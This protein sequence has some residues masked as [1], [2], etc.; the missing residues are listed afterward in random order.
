[1]VYVYTGMHKDVTLSR[2]ANIR[3]GELGGQFWVHLITFG[4]G[5]LLGL[6]TTLFPLTTDFV[7]AWLQP[8]TQSFK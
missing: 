6:L 7:V 4:M 5:P 8:G 2:I 1:M 3:P